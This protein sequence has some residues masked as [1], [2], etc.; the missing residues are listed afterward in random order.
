MLATK[1]CSSRQ[2]KLIANYLG[3][4]RVVASGARACHPGDISSDTWLGECKTHMRP[5]ARIKFVFKEWAKIYEEATSKFKFP[6][7]FVDDGSQTIENTWCMLNAKTTLAKSVPEH[8]FQIVA[9]SSLFLDADA[10][11]ECDSS[12]RKM[13]LYNFNGELV[14]VLRLSTFKT[15]C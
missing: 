7:L 3:W 13:L 15:I 11:N 10:I 4:K 12:K 9:K 5:G 2:E 8:E 14:V 6:A 1:D